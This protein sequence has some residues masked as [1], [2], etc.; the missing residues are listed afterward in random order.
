MLRVFIAVPQDDSWRM[1]VTSGPFVD[2]VAVLRAIQDEL[3]GLDAD[4]FVV[5]AR[6]AVEAAIA[7]A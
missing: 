7:A 1:L 5:K 4:P 2:R 6:G 3:A